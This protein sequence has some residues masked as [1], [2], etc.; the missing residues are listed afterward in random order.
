MRPPAA[1]LEQLKVLNQTHRI[2][3]ALCRSRNPDFLLETIQRQVGGPFH[4]SRSVTIT[5]EVGTNCSTTLSRRNFCGYV[6]HVS[7][8]TI[9]SRMLTIACCLAVGLGLRL[10]FELDLVSGCAHVFI[11]VYVNVFVFVVTRLCEMTLYT[12]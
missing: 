12:F 2:G 1:V 10:G 3:H 5:I 6:G 8:V 4:F 9:F 7:D 11:H